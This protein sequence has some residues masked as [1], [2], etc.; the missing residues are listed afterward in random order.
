MPQ[1]HVNHRLQ[2]DEHPSQQDERQ[3]HG[4]H[5]QLRGAFELDPRS[6]E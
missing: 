1:R 4:V 5:L 6:G 2:Q 3:Q